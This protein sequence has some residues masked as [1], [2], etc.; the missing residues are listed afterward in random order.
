MELIHLGGERT[1]TGSCHLLRVNGVN[2]L[3]DCG[4]AQGGDRVLPDPDIPEPCDLLVM[5]STYG[6]RVHGERK[7]RIERL[8]AVLSQ[9]L[10]D[11]GEGLYSGILF[12]AE[13]GAD[14]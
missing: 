10:A 8:G 5:E 13:S 2:I 7:F 6:D 1:V 9:A 12:G 14:L 11:G 4:L 3:V